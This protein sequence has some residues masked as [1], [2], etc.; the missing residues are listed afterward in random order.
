MPEFQVTSIL[1]PP[2]PSDAACTEMLA[3]VSV[4]VSEPPEKN[5]PTERM[6]AVGPLM[7]FGAHW[8]LRIRK[9]AIQ[10]PGTELLVHGPSL[11]G[12]LVIGHFWIGTVT[13]FV[14]RFVL[15]SVLMHAA[16]SVESLHDAQTALGTQICGCESGAQLLCSVSERQVAP[17]T[18]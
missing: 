17:P 12:S 2:P 15:I 5:A 14:M 7:V 11:S 10:P 6:T 1:Q 9:D 16:R 3:F 13:V 8:P 4:T 18:T